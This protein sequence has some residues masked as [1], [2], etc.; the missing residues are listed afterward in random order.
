M[1]ILGE[2]PTG[3]D[4]ELKEYLEVKQKMFEKKNN[5]DETK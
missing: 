3:V 2:R 1:S 4:E 5:N